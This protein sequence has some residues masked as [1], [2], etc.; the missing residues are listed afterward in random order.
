MENGGEEWIETTSNAG[1]GWPQA[2]AAARTKPPV[3]EEI[4]RFMG[5]PFL[6]RFF[7]RE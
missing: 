1:R 4:I 2:M 5:T 7:H 3:N 6:N